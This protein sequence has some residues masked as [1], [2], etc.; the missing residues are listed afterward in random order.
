MTSSEPWPSL[1]F[2]EWRETQA[3]LHMWL[4]IVGKTQ[5]ALTPLQNHWWNTALRVTARGLATPPMPIAKAAGV[6]SDA[7][8]VELDFVDHILVVRTSGG[9]HLPLRL[10]PRSVA[11]FFMQ[12]RTLLR[13]IGAEPAIHAQP[14]EVPVA[15]PFGEDETHASYDAAAAQRCWRIL[16][17]TTSV[18]DTF[19]AQFLGKCSPV[20]FWWGGFDLACTRFSGRPAPKHPGGIPNCPDFVMHEAYSHEC[21]SAGW[22]PGAGLGEPA[23]YAY[24]YPEPAG[25]A[26]A[27]I[28]PR[29]ASYHSGMHEW[30]LPYDAVRQ[31][32]SPEAMLTEFL[33][34]TYSAASTLGGWDRSALERPRFKASVLV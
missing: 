32:R 4:Q 7:F 9:E 11:D 29:A 5:L 2:D 17:S 10:H 23:F 20:H 24:A 22:W 1:P 31:S 27:S 14:V 16:A 33:E 34:S 15:I 6:A 8:D 26:A 18:L 3:T 19:R 25:C 30:I 13:S 12:Y 21:I 28:R